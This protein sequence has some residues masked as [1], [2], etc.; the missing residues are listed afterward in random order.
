VKDPL[1][2]YG[3]EK[4]QKE[5]SEVFEPQ[6]DISVPANVEEWETKWWQTQL[7]GYRV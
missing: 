1:S 3:V 5:M 2:K 4:F 6:D 7:R